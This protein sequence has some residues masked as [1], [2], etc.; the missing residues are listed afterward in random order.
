MILS[1]YHYSPPFL[2]VQYYKYFLVSEISQINKAFLTA[3]IV[4]SSSQP[5]M[6]GLPYITHPVEMVKMTFDEFHVYDAEVAMDEILHDTDEPS[7][8]PFFNQGIQM[9]F[10]VSVAEDNQLLTKTDANKLIYLED[11]VRSGKWRV[12]LSKLIDRLHNMRTLENSRLEFKTKQATETRKYF[13]P[14]CNELSKI[15]PKKYE[16]VPPKIF[17]ELVK[18]C[19]QYGC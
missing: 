11:I 1:Q 15:I 13:L 9:Q 14:L 3:W 8:I 18:L 6:N 17:I 7:V 4:H 19:E 16:A 10:G 5:R 12:C 2:E